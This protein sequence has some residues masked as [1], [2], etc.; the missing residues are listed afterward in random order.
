MSKTLNLVEVFYS[1]QGEGYNA[2]RAA[3]F[4]RTSG[5][6]LS[7]VF[8]KD[9]LCDTPYQQTRMRVTLDELFEAV[10]P[11]MLPQS[12]LTHTGPR[13]AHP[14][15]RDQQPTQ[16]ERIMLVLTGGEPTM[17][18]LFGPVI[19]RGQEE[20]FYV[21]VETN[22]TIWHDDFVFCD[23]VSVSPKADVVQGSPGK[24]HNQNPQSP[25]LHDHVRR[26]M[27]A[28]ADERNEFRYVLGPSSPTPLY[29]PAYRSYVSPAALSDGEGMEMRDGFQGFVPGAR[30]RCI[31]LVTHDPR[32]RL[33][34]QTHKLL[35]IR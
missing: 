25:A 12:L 19:R 22:G 10:I 5:C 2:G 31:E 7:C 15:R 34:L 30:N 35:G 29:S 23:W 3:V 16:D 21:A 18:P 13:G 28:T 11:G 4:V 8:A 24:Y 27:E 33:S 26:W 14:R 6:N 17:Q 1:L 32:W 20:G 9:A